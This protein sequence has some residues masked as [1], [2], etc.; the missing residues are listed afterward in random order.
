M[1]DHMGISGCCWYPKALISLLLRGTNG[2]RLRP[3][4]ES[5]EPT[6]LAT[7]PMKIS[8]LKIDLHLILCIDG[9]ISF[10]F[11]EIHSSRWKGW[12]FHLRIYFC[13]KQNK[14]K[15]LRS[16]LKFAEICWDWKTVLWYFNRLLLRNIHPFENS[17]QYFTLKQVKTSAPS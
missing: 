3:I 14:N 17:K 9:F 4:K 1:G 15:A 2:S 11:C 10:R 16:N 7:S 5:S 12:K 6:E 13:K 8:L